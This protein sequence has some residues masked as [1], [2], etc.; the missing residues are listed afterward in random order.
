MR[1]LV[2]RRIDALLISYLVI[3]FQNR[4]PHPI[5]QF[6]NHDTVSFFTLSSSFFTLIVALHVRNFLLQLAYLLFL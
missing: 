5:L 4:I 2:E 6:I 3:F 1:M